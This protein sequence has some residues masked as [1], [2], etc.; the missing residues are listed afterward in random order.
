MPEHRFNCLGV[1]HR[2]GPAVEIANLDLEV[3]FVLQIFGDARLPLD[4][5]CDW[6]D[7]QEASVDPTDKLMLQAFEIV[8]LVSL[9]DRGPVLVLG[10][11]RLDGALNNRGGRLHRRAAVVER[12]STREVGVLNEH[13]LPSQRQARS[14]VVPRPLRL[15]VQ[16][17]DDLS[18]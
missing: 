12:L 7:R 8:E 15:G 10:N 9:F 14:A 2:R 6:F 4:V 11:R 13:R 3:T 17:Q 18:G 5:L 16:Y 1:D